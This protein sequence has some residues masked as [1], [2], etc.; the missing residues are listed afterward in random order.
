MMNYENKVW[1]SGDARMT[2]DV[3]MVL[4]RRCPWRFVPFGPNV[5]EVYTAFLIFHASACGI[6]TKLS[7]KI[8]TTL[9]V[10]AS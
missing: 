10:V 7:I 2:V 3:M 5:W 8:S 4:E 9:I 6:T 1:V